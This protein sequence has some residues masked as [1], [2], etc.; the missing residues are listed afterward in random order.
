MRGIPVY[1]GG[2]IGVPDSSQD[3]PVLP[4]GYMQRPCGACRGTGIVR[5]TYQCG[6]C[7]GQGA[8]PKYGPSQI[9]QQARASLDQLERGFHAAG[10]PI[11]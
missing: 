5:E 11:E 9:E 7:Q 3:G 8:F 6:T 4:E 2:R 1:P 10:Q